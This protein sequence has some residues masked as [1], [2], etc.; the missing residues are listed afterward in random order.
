MPATNVTMVPYL[1]A[2][3]YL[4][5]FVHYSDFVSF[6]HIPQAYI[7]IACY[8]HVGSVSLSISYVMLMRS[9]KAEKAVHGC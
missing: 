1:V 5:T 2:I 7:F 9:N 8:L 3:V 4:S 6:S